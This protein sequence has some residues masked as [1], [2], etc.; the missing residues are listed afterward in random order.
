[1]QSFPCSSQLSY[2]RK[3]GFGRHDGP[4]VNCWTSLLAKKA[5][6]NGNWGI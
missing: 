5:S 4:R 3:T 1:V 2:L 6:Y